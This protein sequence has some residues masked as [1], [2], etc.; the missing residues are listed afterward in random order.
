MRWWWIIIINNNNIIWLIIT[1]IVDDLLRCHG[2]APHRRNAHTIAH[3]RTFWAALGDSILFRGKHHLYNEELSGAPPRPLVFF[4]R[5][6]STGLVTL[7]TDYLTALNGTRVVFVS[8]EW[9]HQAANYYNSLGSCPWYVLASLVC[10]WVQLLVASQPLGYLL[11][12][13]WTSMGTALVSF[14]IKTTF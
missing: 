9:G 1:I 2:W 7:G 3:R 14:W 6:P 4:H 8:I 12:L 5:L 10:Q 11:T 13:L